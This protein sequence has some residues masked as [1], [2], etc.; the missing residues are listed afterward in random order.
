MRSV[1]GRPNR[2]G[3][4]CF[5]D[6]LLIEREDGVMGAL[7][8]GRQPVAFN[9]YEVAG[10]GAQIGNIESIFMFDAAIVSPFTEAS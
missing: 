4:H 5:R 8:F 6:L 3:E 2:G 10:E 1:R 7:K 9:E